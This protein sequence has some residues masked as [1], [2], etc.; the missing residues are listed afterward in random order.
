MNYTKEQNEAIKK[1]EAFLESPDSEYV[2]D[3]KAGCGKTTIL[4][5]VIKSKEQSVNVIG[6]TVSHKAKIVL[7]RS[8]SEVCTV[9][10]ALGM[11]AQYDEKGE[12]SF[13]VDKRRD[14]IPPIY[15]ANIVVIDEASQISKFIL[16]EIRDNI[17]P[18][19]KVIYVG[20][21]HQLPPIDDSR[22]QDEDSD[23]FKIENRVTLTERIRQGVDNPIVALSDLIADQIE[24][25]HDLGFLKK[26]RNDYDKKLGKGFILTSKEKAIDNFVKLFKAGVGCKITAFRNVTIKKYNK[27]IRHKLYGDVAKYIKGEMIIANNTYYVDDKPI[28]YNSDEVIIKAVSNIKHLSVDCFAIDIYG[29]RLIVPT[30]KGEA[31]HKANLKRLADEATSAEKWARG[32]KWGAFYKYKMSFAD[33]DYAYAISTHKSQGSTYNTVYVDIVDILN[34]VPTSSKEKLQSIYVAVTRA[35]KNLC[36]I[37]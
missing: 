7:S 36:I 27:D 6:V 31:Q 17:D 24:Q 3:G 4:K 33:I 16:K 10:H 9:A 29:G 34:V 11:K 19:T 35:S 2:L 18:F 30:E 32:K 13:V 12:M 21:S 23:V 22:V 8:I 14:D 15:T 28:I 25:G 1:L 20:D 26:I 37:K 5:E